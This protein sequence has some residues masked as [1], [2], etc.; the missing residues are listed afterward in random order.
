MI[1]H[2]A[3]GS[4]NAEEYLPLPIS[5][6]Y[7]LPSKRRRHSAQGETT[8]AAQPGS[9]SKPDKTPFTAAHKALPNKVRSVPPF[10][11]LEASQILLS[12]RELLGLAE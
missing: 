10:L 3:D 8:R 6:E 9:A 4:G 1:L 5:E 7:Q 11:D 12:G 2:G